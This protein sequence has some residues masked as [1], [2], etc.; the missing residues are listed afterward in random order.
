MYHRVSS[1]FTV[2]D[3]SYRELIVSDNDFEYNEEYDLECLDYILEP[4]EYFRVKRG[5]VVGVCYEEDSENTLELVVENTERELEILSTESCLINI[6]QVSNQSPRREVALL[7]S[8]Y[9]DINECLLGEAM[10]H[11]NAACSDVVGGENSYNC[12]CNPGFT[13]DGFS[14]VGN[15]EGAAEVSTAT[16]VGDGGGS[17]GTTEV[18]TS[19][20][21]RPTSNNEVNVSITPPDNSKRRGQE[22][23]SVVG[24]IV[25]AFVVVFLII[26]VVVTSIILYLSRQRI[27][28]ALGRTIDLRRV[29]TSKRTD[30]LAKVPDEDHDYDYVI[31]TGQPVDNEYETVNKT[32]LPAQTSSVVPTSD[33]EVPVQSL[34]CKFDPP[35]KNSPQYEAMLSAPSV[36]LEV[37]KGTD[38]GE[39]GAYASLIQRTVEQHVYEALSPYQA[40]AS[41]QESLYAQ[42]GSYNIRNISRENLEFV[43]RLGT[44][45]F[46]KVNKAVWTDGDE[47]T[48]EVAVKT[49]TDSANTVKFLQEAAIMAQFKHPNILTLHGV[50][51][52]G[53]LKMIVLELMHNGELKSVVTGMRPTSE[54]PLMQNAPLKLMDFSKEVALGLHYLSCRGFVHRDLAARN[55]LVSQN[56]IC[57]I[58]DFGLS[59]DLAVVEDDIYV[60]RGGK[61]PLKWC[62]PEAIFHRK[63]STASDVWSYGCVLYEIWSLG[64]KPFEANQSK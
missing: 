2:V 30:T 31:A 18:G 15:S 26:A 32:P 41:K 63:Y 1:V 34:P 7:L 50:V 23:D 60:S 22:N 61:I 27:E 64:H 44:G 38:S 35:L 45:Q 53:E 57:K 42:L 47:E 36:K 46:G 11:E 40:P 55:I 20:N 17:E 13:G 58:S 5:D 28:Q 49:L 29:T 14:C 52:A 12:T 43:S 37:G 59:R 39:S 9:I 6:A 16:E 48:V 10:C 21:D 25:A 51:S 19:S 4:S 56:Y 8:V 33:Y 24:A 54:Q 3:G 62:A